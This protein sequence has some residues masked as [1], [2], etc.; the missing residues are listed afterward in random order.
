MLGCIGK[1]GLGMGGG[2]TL[3]ELCV[4][5]GEEGGGGGGGLETE[6]MTK[7][8]VEQLKKK[9]ILSGCWM[10]RRVDSMVMVVILAYSNK[11]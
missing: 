8:E 9:Q 4:G 2:K 11:F 1:L 10:E 3:E 6:R 7:G 5:G